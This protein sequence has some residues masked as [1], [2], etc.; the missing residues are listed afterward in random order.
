MVKAF[1]VLS[2]AYHSRRDDPDLIAE[3]QEHAKRESAPY[4]YPRL[5][6]FVDSMPVTVSGKTRRVELREREK[7][8]VAAVKQGDKAKAK[9]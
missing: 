2:P 9:L 6:E 4:K 3:I 8:R 7:R 1:I 5:V